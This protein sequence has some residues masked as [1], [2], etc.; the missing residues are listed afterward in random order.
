MTLSEALDAVYGHSNW[1]NPIRPYFASGVS[2]TPYEAYEKL[3][4]EYQKIVRNLIGHEPLK[5]EE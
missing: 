4:P 2:Q 5:D 1:V 3:K